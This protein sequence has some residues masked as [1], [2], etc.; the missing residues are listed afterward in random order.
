MVAGCQPLILA[1]V[2]GMGPYATAHAVAVQWSPGVYGSGLWL[3]PRQRARLV[4]PGPG[5]GPPCRCV[6]GSLRWSWTGS[7][8]EPSV[9]TG[10]G[11]VVRRTKELL[12]GPAL[13]AGVSAEPELQVPGLGNPLREV[14]V[15][16]PAHRLVVSLPGTQ[17]RV[18]LGLFNKYPDQ[19]VSRLDSGVVARRPFHRRLLVSPASRLSRPDGRCRAALP[20]PLDASSPGSWP[21]PFALA[22]PGT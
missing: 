5:N 21:R 6:G 18:F 17:R 13:V 8:T 10:R 1:H 2:R 22:V 12:S 9:Q 11:W 3:C 20:A 16:F 7:W 19:Q 15:Q 14:A 4:R